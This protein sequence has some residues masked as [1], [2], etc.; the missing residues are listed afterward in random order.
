MSRGLSIEEAEAL[1]IDCSKLKGAK[2]H[3][4]H[5]YGVSVPEKRTIAGKVYASRAEAIRRQDLDQ[6]LLAGVLLEVLEQPRLWL[7]VRANVY[8]P[9]FLVV[10]A[11]GIPWYE[12][13]KGVETAAFKR[14]V[15][16]WREFGRL[17]LRILTRKRGDWQR[18]SI[19]PPG[20]PDLAGRPHA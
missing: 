11:V 4:R 5:K 15:R 16:L 9:D 7:G 6:L 19:A 17:E 3:R 13:V 12:D 10:P 1:G 2:V 14:N 18:R 8:V 20:R